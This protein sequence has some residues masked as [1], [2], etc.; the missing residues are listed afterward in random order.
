MGHSSWAFPWES[1]QTMLHSHSWDL[2]LWVPVIA[3]E[4][5]RDIE[6]TKGEGDRDKA[7]EDCP[8]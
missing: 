2:T 1:W 8:V 6:G 3:E 7:E 4:T 5:N